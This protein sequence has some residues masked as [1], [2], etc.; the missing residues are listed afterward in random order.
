MGAGGHC[1]EMGLGRGVVVGDYFVNSHKHGV[2]WS[3][4]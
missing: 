3:A 1:H 2:D 4:S